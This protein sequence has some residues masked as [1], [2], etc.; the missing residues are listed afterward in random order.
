MYVRNKI[1][2]NKV[3]SFLIRVL[4]CVVSAE[5]AAISF[6]LYDQKIFIWSNWQFLTVDNRINNLQ[7]NA[8]NE[9]SIVDV[10]D[11]EDVKNFYKC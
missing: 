6:I 5:V 9:L 8:A 3:L 11:K 4:I 10:E 2:N 7:E 1:F